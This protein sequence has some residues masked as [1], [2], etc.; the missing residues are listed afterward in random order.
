MNRITVQVRL[1]ADI[2][3]VWNYWTQAEH[4]CAWNFADKSWH[5]PR[6]ENDLQVGRQFNWRMEA[7]DGSMGFDFTGTYE[8][9][10]PQQKISYRLSDNRAVDIDFESSDE[11]VLLRESFE[12]E[13]SNADEMQRAGWQAILENFKA[14][15]ESN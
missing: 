4:I 6:A 15:V 12:A 5:C 3:K 7:K 2:E 13:G 10:L 1:E 8:T 9:I 14:Y 11:G